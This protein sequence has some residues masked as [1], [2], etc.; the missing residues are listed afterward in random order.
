ML[1]TGGNPS[2]STA[3]VVAQLRPTVE[4]GIE[5]LRPQIAK[6]TGAKFFMQVPQDITVGGH[7]TQAQYQ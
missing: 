5:E 7:L 1:A 2:E 3:R 4:Q 6:V